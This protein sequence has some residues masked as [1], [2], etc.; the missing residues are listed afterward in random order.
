MC[1]ILEMIKKIYLG[2]VEAFCNKD[3]TPRVI[4]IAHTPEMTLWDRL[5]AEGKYDLIDKLRK[6]EQGEPGYRTV[7]IPE[8]GW[9]ESADTNDA[10]LQWL[11][12]LR[13]NVWSPEQEVSDLEKTLSVG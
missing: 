13:V 5:A 9:S 12:S 11:K 3:K 10:I 4:R 8:G 6:T 2:C 1:S 7:I